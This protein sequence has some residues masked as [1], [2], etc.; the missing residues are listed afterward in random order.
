MQLQDLDNPGSNLT[1][2]YMQTIQLDYG[3]FSN[4]SRTNIEF[5]TV[6]YNYLNFEGG[7]AMKGSFVANIDFEL[8]A[9][10][11]LQFG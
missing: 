1:I 2:Q 9:N 10:V 6:D 8:V 7:L 11:T 5:L 3:T 4:I